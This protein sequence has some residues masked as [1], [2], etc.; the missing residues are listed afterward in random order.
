LDYYKQ[1]EH[2]FKSM[3]G[4]KLATYDEAEKGNFQYVVLEIDEE[5]CGTDI[6]DLVRVLHAENVLVRRYFYPAC[7]QM[8]PYQFQ[9]TPKNWQ[10]PA[11]ERV[12]ERVLCLPTG[13]SIGQDEIDAICQI[14]RFVVEQSWEVRRGLCSTQTSP[15]RARSL[16]T[17]AQRVNRKKFEEFSRADVHQLGSGVCQR[18]AEK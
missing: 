15:H 8:Q 1:Y 18:Y 2:H 16:L 9:V 6:S 17:S 14:I 3:T 7:H 10:L 12:S 11:T 13:T 4:I 5:V